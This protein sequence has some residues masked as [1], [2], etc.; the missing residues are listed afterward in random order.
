MDGKR[1]WQMRCPDYCVPI[2]EN[3]NACRPHIVLSYDLRHCSCIS[4]F[5]GNRFLLTVIS[6]ISGLSISQPTGSTTGQ[7]ITSV[8]M[9]FMNFSTGSMRGHGIH[10]AGLWEAR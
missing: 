9:V 6:V 10:L 7:L 5:Y 4:T 1:A 2:T 3:A 8:L